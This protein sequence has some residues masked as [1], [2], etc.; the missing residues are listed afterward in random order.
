MTGK[1]PEDTC[2]NAGANETL[3]D[4]APSHHRSTDNST[5]PLSD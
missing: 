2:A 5:N 3:I 1:P 4:C